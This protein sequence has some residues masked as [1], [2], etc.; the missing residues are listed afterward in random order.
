[1]KELGQFS[2]LDLL[3]VHCKH[4]GGAASPLDGSAEGLHR[5]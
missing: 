5:S 1:M 4:G 2:D 3:W